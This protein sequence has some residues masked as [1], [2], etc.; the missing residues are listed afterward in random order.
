MN[1]TVLNKTDLAAWRS[2]LTRPE[3][4]ERWL[5][6]GIYLFAAFIIPNVGTTMLCA[7][8]V[9]ACVAY[10]VTRTNAF[11][12]LLAPGIPALLL[13]TLTGSP[14]PSA[15]FLALLFGGATG[16]ILI[17]SVK[18]PREGLL[19]TLLPLLAFFAA[20]PLC[21][22][23][24]LA[25]LTLIPLPIALVGALALRRCKPFC[26]AVAALAAAL[27]A[28]LAAVGII[29]L[30]AN[31]MSLNV[32]DRLPALMDTLEEAVL[33]TA[34]ETAAL[35]PEID[36]SEVLSPT[37]VHNML[38]LT[39]NLSPGIFVALCLVVAYFIWRTL[40]TLLV[41]LRMLPRLP[42]VF[43]TPLPGAV[44]AI[45][46]IL[47]FLTALFCGSATTLAGA[48]AENLALMLTPVFV[49]IGF[50]ALFGHG[51]QRSCLS[52]LL[53]IGMAYLLFN[54]PP[55]ALNFAALYGAIQALIVAHRSAKANNNSKGEP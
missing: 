44:S 19:L 34:K 25:L 4:G 53:L 21:G 38:A 55:L 39:V 3:G 11:L 54:N 24:L 7:L 45:V 5:A 6:A 30:L 32:I 17:S 8:F 35:Y 2:L 43:T 42:R 16:S 1:G 41:A 33:E 49:L 52:V 29:T 48:V 31:G 37:A 46:F 20:W 36:V 47:A 14:A 18:S 28:T 15:I 13:F 9:A 51:A 22:S 27:V 23:P 40:C 50:A 12:P 26:T 10:L